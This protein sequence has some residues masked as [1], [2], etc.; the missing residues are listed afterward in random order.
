MKRRTAKVVRKT[1]E[2]NISIE[3][4]LDGSG[5]YRISTGL[6]F[7]DHMLELL[8]KHS[9]VDMK[10]KAVGDLAVDYH[11]TVEDIGLVLGSALDKALGTRRAISR[12][13]AAYVPMDEALC[14]VVVDLGGRPYLVKDMK[15]RKRKL[16][17][18]DLSLFD[19]FFRA[20]TVESRMNLH[21][22]QFYGEE[23]HH[24]YEAVFKA[25]ARALRQAC[26]PDKRVK[27]VPSSKGKI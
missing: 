12:Y 13:G 10:L 3:L 11:H 15:C 14:R 7:M 27:G 19:D 6:P 22:T 25:F 1:R 18:F 16:L 20:M 21:I 4:D 26:S 17:D 5:L 23:A 2:T 9:L 24:A 8:S